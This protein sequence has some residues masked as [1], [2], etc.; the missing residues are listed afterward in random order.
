MGNCFNT[1]DTQ[2]AETKKTRDEREKQKARSGTVSEA[3]AITYKLKIQRDRMD[4]RMK[5]L[6]KQEK[7]LTQKISQ[8]LKAGN[9]TQA[10]FEL[11]KRKMVNT[12]Y[13]D[14]SN[15]ALFIEKQINNVE[16]MQ[17]DAEFTK[18]LAASNKV[19]TDLKKEIDM[20]EI[21]TA[22]ELNREYAM[23]R[24]EMNANMEDDDEDTELMDE[25]N[26]MEAAMMN[27]EFSKVDGEIKNK[28]VEFHRKATMQQHQKAM[29]S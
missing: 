27:N 23:D 4:S 24:E 16:R 29:A 9:K 14:Y 25:I 17:D 20:E 8:N 28:N 19:L 1:E 7:D 3:D 13:L 15:R 21:A 5:A 12:Q 10:K 18:T 2:G 26:A 22:N 11:S 6:Q